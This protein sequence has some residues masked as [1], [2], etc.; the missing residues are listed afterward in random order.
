MM[1]LIIDQEEVRAISQERFEIQ[2]Q[3]VKHLLENVVVLLCCFF[4]VITMANMK[5]LYPS[6]GNQRSQK[7]PYVRKGFCIYSGK[8]S[9]PRPPARQAHAPVTEPPGSK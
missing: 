5:L 7:V 2:F 1:L 3:H 9:I 4:I 6:I 8:E